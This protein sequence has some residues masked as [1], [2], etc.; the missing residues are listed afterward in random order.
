M[1]FSCRNKA[2]K[3]HRSQIYSTSCLNSFLQI[4]QD[5]MN[6]IH[7]GNFN[8]RTISNNIYVRG[9][10]EF[11]KIY[12]IQ[13][14]KM[15]KKETINYRQKARETSNVRRGSYERISSNYKT[16]H[17]HT[18]THRKKHTQPLQFTV[19]SDCLYRHL[20]HAPGSAV[21]KKCQKTD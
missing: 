8:R 2:Q 12:I 11:R 3:V 15:K 6:Q 18:H 13:L 10:L 7:A 4:C 16:T 21:S 20:S 14:S 9:E 5:Q 1:L 19:K 17:T